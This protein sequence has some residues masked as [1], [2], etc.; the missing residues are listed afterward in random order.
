MQHLFGSLVFEKRTDEIL[1]K[2][3]SKLANLRTKIAERQGRVA[4][5]RSEYAIDDAA[6]SDLLMQARQAQRR[7]EA[8]LNYTYNPATEGPDAPAN[9]VPER[10]IGA[11]VINNLL[12][13]QDFIDGDREAVRRLELIGRNLRDVFD[14]EV[15]AAVV[16]AAPR[17]LP[18]STLAA[19]ELHR[20]SYDE[21]EYLGF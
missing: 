14:R 10:S 5:L 21:L 2:V 13:E 3:E 7:N 8:V 17:D 20:L 12:T 15:L 4:R 18:G 19:M 9:H 6:L 11:G 16:V 1:P